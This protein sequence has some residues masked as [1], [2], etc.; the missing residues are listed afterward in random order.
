[1]KEEEK[2]F[3]VIEISKESYILLSKILTLMDIVN[4]IHKEVKLPDNLTVMPFGTME[5]EKE[6]I[7]EEMLS[8]I[9]E[10]TVEDFIILKITDAIIYSCIDSLRNHTP[11]DVMEALISHGIN[12]VLLFYISIP[13]VDTN[14][15]SI[16]MINTL[17][18]ELEN[19]FMDV[20]NDYTNKLITYDVLGKFKFVRFYE[21][22]TNYVLLECRN[23]HGLKIKEER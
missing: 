20:V 5:K 19:A 6:I 7:P 1:M 14:R 2:E 17:K 22:Q 15:E 12:E 21:V 4:L 3:V 16:E 11:I 9:D 18:Y 10:E 13:D 23:T 8:E